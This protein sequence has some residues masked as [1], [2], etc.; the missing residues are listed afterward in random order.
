MFRIQTNAEQVLLELM[1]DVRRVETNMYSHLRAAALDAT[2]LVAHRVQQQGKN[3]EGSRMRTRSVLK[4]GA[5]SQGHAKRR[6][7]RGRQTEHVDLTLE[8]DLMRNW[9]PIDITDT[10]ATVGF[11]DNRQ[12][13][14]AEYLEAY[15]GPIFELSSDEQEQVAGGLEDNILKD[16][17]V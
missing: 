10:S 9:G 1:E 8:G 13:D 3:A 16:L 4:N 17:K 11:T 12:A 7:E 15:Y 5:Y 2:V 6:S 14:K